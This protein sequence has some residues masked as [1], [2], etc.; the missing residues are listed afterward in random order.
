[1]S[2]AFWDKIAHKYAARP[3]DDIPAYEATLAAVAERLSATDRLIEFGCGTGSTAIRLAPS[4]A[5]MVATDISPGMI[6]IAKG[7]D[8]PGNLSFRVADPAQ[9]QP[10]GP[11]D[12]ACAFNLL[13][14]T[15]DLPSAIRA[16]MAQVKPGGLLITKT[17]CI[18]EM[19]PVFRVI[20][21]LMRLVG[22]AP[23]AN[24]FDRRILEQGFRGAGC[25][26]LEHGHFGSAD[27]TRYIVARKI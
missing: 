26:I 8:A 19:S 23:A 14:L 18:G 24:F 10:D 22:K 21:P 6:Q 1:M 12:A 4:V 15:P 27:R 16:M 17:P 2:V 13:H 11:F 25:E 7:K 3:V 5:E 20:L 9:S